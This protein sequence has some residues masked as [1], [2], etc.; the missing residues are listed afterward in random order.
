MERTKDELECG[1]NRS[2]LLV[3]I[4]GLTPPVAL[5]GLLPVPSMGEGRGL[6]MG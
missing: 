1:I 2:Y 4:F 5:L 6:G 3:I